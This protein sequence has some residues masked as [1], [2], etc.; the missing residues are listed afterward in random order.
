MDPNNNNQ[1]INTNP[2]GQPV[3][4]SQPE[5]S[6]PAPSSPVPP[7]VAP[8]QPTMT[9]P[10]MP[11]MQ[12][13]P[14]P[15]P[16][17]STMPPTAPMSAPIAPPMTAAPQPTM[18]PQAPKSGSRKGPM[19]LVLLLIL[20]LGMVAYVMLA[21]KQINTAK[22]AAT[23]STSVVIPTVTIQPTATPA[24]VEQLNV[25]SPETDLNGIDTAVQ[26]L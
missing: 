22:K 24:S 8:T 5:M 2:L 1:T 19:L 3:A 20:V 9:V 21:N 23:Q 26:G 18:T 4:P 12:P 7:V 25:T 16:S 6:V 11:T 13:E 14:Q 15:Q 17:I 10:P